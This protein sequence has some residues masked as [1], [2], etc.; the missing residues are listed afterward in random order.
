[1][2]RLITIKEKST[3]D[4]FLGASPT[5]AALNPPSLGMVLKELKK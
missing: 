1:M 4:E 3:K 2:K 5:K